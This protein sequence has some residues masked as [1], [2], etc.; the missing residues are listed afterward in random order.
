MSLKA[1]IGCFFIL[2]A[3][4]LLLISFKYFEKKEKNEDQLEDTSEMM[5]FGLGGGKFQLILFTALST[6]FVGLTLLDVWSY[7]K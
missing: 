1:V 5:L 7:F 2:M 3:I 6:L 4:F